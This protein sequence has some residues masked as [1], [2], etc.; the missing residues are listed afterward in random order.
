MVDTVRSVP[1]DDV[2]THGHQDAV[3]R[4]H[5]WRTA[6][7]SASYL[8][9]ALEPGMD[10]LDVGCGPGTL[11]VDLA[12][13]VAPGRVV[14]VDVSAAVIEDARAHAAD[15]GVTNVSFEAGDFRTREDGDFDVVHAH[16]V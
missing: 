16:Q 2:Y 3:L 4:S 15:A 7:N 10:V 12:R 5:R 8:L 6:E 1:P 11:T 14:G 9:P 13:R